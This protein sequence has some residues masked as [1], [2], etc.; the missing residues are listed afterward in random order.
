M[1]LYHNQV[2]RMQGEFSIRMFHRSWGLMMIQQNLDN[3]TTLLDFPTEKQFVA[4]LKANHYDVVGISGIIVNI[5]KVREMCRV[6]R[7]LSPDSVIVVGGHVAAVPGIEGMIDADHIVKGEGISWMRSYLGQDPAQPVKHPDIVSGF[8][9][10]I[11]GV[12]I[13]E[14]F[15]RPAATLI[16]SVGCPMG[17]NFCTTSS[18]FGGKGK[19]HNFYETGDELYEVMCGQEERLKVHSFF[20]MDE[21]FLLQRKRALRL[22]ERMK[23]GKKSWE[24]YVFSSAN[25]IRKYT[26]E[27]LVQLGVSWIWLGLESPHSDYAKLSGA[28]TVSLTRELRAHG[29]KLLGS[30]IIGLEHHTPQNIREEIDYAIS[31]D[32]DF[33]QFMLYTPVPGTPLYKQIESEG[34]LLDVDLADIHGQDRFN[35]EHAAI[36][37]EASKKYLDQAFWRDFERNGPSLFRICRTTF[38]GWKR[39]RNS[40]DLRVRERFTRELS[41]LRHAYTG[42]LWAMER[43]LRESNETVSRRIH[44]LRADIMRESGLDARLASAV[45]GPLMLWAARRERKRLDRG[46]TYEP[47][48][49]VERHN[50]AAAAG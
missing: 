13:P 14:R 1:E 42:I 2:T 5:G 26:M 24:L 8:G 33:H 15:H 27:E 39:Y 49:V 16:P 11:M 12:H 22:L 19:F 4:E 48:C 45:V 21:N 28:D 25:A 47:K 37:R 41:S 6:V 9:H 46:S 36:S 20:I 17:C 10:R 43:R 3:P 35:F 31:H 29:I 50:W 44:S 18:F 40:P 38:E 30:T 32:T 23:E 34:R 7:E